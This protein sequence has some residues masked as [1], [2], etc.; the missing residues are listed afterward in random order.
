MSDSDYWRK[1]EAWDMYERMADAEDRADLVARIYRTAS[2]QIVFSAQDIFEKYATKHKLSKAEAWK[3]LNSI[4]DKDSINKLIQELKNKDSGEN[5]QEL[6]KELEAPAYRFRLE[7]LQDLLR[8]VDTVMQNVYQQE[9]QFDT[10]FFEGLAENTYYKTIYNIQRRTGLRFSFSKIDQK[11]IDHALKINWSGKHYS[12]RIWKNTDELAE[13]VKDELLVSLLTGRTERETAAIITEKFGG[14]ASRARRLIRTESCF[15]SGE[16][17]AQA[18]EECNLTKYIFLATLDLRTS[19][20]CKELDGRKF[21]LKN[22]QIG[23]NYPPMHPWCRSTTVSYISEDELKNLERRAYNPKTGRTELVPASMTYDQWYE[24]Y[25]KNDPK[26]L[27][28]EKAIKNAVSDRKQYKQYQEVLGKDAPKSFVKYQELKYN[29]PE[30][31]ELF[32]TYAHSV[33]NGM[34]SPLSGFKNYQKIYDEINEKVIGVKTSEGSEVTRQSKHFMERAIGTMKDPKTGRSRSGVSVE[35]I[36]DAL[37][38]PMTVR[39]IR[40]DLQGERSQ[41]YIG[42]KATVSVDPD[43][44]TLIQCNPT[45]EKLLRSIQN[46]KI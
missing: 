9:Q 37:E 46:G 23:K 44:G 28:Q 43:T 20:I 32:R 45:N 2:T 12:R 21:L 18:Y 4:K 16:L 33:K 30:K 27:V 29:E 6:I 10:S 15:L 25:V 11:Q 13:T 26:A 40:T 35:G 24:K 31:W 14:G 3:L 1:R 8:Q 38:N 22:R 34:I 36:K 42:E 7:R 17:N 39:A 19:K 41:K 5:K